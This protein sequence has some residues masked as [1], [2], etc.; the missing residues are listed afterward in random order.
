M[1][2]KTLPASDALANLSQFDSI[3]DART[4][5]EHAEDH[6]PG[7][8]NWPSLD[9]EQR[10]VVGTLYKQVNAFEAKKRGAAMVA[11]NVAAHIERE[12]LDKPKGWK[13]LVYCWRGGNRSGAMAT[14]FSAIGFHVTL[15]EGGYK[16]FR[17]AVLADIPRLAQN[18]NFRV[19]CGPTGV[20]KTRLLH[21][22]AHAGAQVLDLE[23]L[24]EHRS[25]VLGSLPG[26]RQPS[27]KLFD[28][29]VWAAL[30]ALDERRPVYVE[31]ESKRV[32][33]VTVDDA[34]MT[35]MRAS[36]CLTVALSPPAR[37]KLL[38]EDYAQFSAD[39]EYFCER[40]ALLTVLRGKNTV[41]AW[42]AQA[43][44]GDTE[45]VVQAL[46]D[47]HYDPK[48]EESMRRNFAAYAQSRVWTPA[49][50][51]SSTLQALAQEI[52]AD[53]GSAGGGAA[54]LIAS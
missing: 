41:A 5:A 28:S 8:V 35:R 25:S 26:Q 34:L 10:I 47:Q 14:I 53:E 20:G 21:A 18:L 27:Q 15:L 45:G 36:P 3:I 39:T 2:L 51:E 13:P 11:R 37:V 7:A 19:V 30:R 49:D 9:N 38:M 48:Y 6:L 1:S 22:L 16:A 31:A 32:G 50:G 42:Q 52:L 46:L 43:R 44:A 33:N 24:A 40:L 23:A 12:L 4:P 29:R 17:Q 54:A